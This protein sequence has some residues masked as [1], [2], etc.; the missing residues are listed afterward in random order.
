MGARSYPPMHAHEEL[1]TRFYHALARRDGDAMAAC[2]HPEVHF[3]DEVFDLHGER[4]SAMWRMLCARGRDLDV[5]ATGIR[6]DDARGVAHWRAEYTFSQT[7]RA[8]RNEIDAAFTFGDG[9]I[10]THRD[11][12]DFWAWSRQALG[13]PGALLGWT[14]W[15][16]RKVAAEAA[17]SLDRFIA[18]PAV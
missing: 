10:V 4:A 16:R 6:A 7:D 2:Y 18:T 12:F 17:R 15:L 1:V 9:L 8:V 14:P 11:R 13:V 3:R 5:V